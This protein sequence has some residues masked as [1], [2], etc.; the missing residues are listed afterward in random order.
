L[1]LY[2][3]QKDETLHLNKMTSVAMVGG[4]YD[5]VVV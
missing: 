1:T 3:E 2:V 5:T 4:R